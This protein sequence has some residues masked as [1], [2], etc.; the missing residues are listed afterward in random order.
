MAEP[1]YLASLTI[2]PLLATAFFALYFGG[3]AG[4]KFLGEGEGRWQAEGAIR[5][6][7]VAL[8]DEDNTSLSRTL[9]SMLS[10]TPAIRIALA[11]NTFEEGRRSLLRGDCY[12]IAL[13]PKGFEQ[14]CLTFG[15]T[16]ILLYNSGCNLTA[17]GFIA[18]AIQTTAE[19]LSVG[20][21]TQSLQAQGLPA[22]Q[23]MAEAMP[24]RF[25][26]HPLFNPRLDYGWYLAPCFMAM[27]LIIF[28]IAAT[29]TAL[30]SELRY[31]TAGEW[32][33]TAGGSFPIALTGKLLLVTLSMTVAALVM[34]V[35]LRLWLGLPIRG[36]AAMLASATLLLIV[37]YEGISLLF[38]ALT[39]SMRLA[40]SLGGGYSV[41][42]FTFSGITLPVMAMARPLQWL[43]QLFPYTHYTN[44]LIDTTLRGAPTYL[45]LDDAARM[46]LFWIPP[47]LL[48][49]RLERICRDSRYW[50]RL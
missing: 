16:H 22:T 34:A 10:A 23:A 20:V 30:G 14:A 32:L 35:A 50:G 4:E 17:N 28:T 48:M 26:L 29:T 40:F 24:L 1:T 36:S 44:I 42:A 5:P 18:K 45:A 19:S 15:T 9:H 7:P 47:L 21:R 3:E 8:I 38:I 41:L 25:D 43:S 37:C 6:L 46:M 13:I 49:P 31:G 27:M 12:A 33:D 11:T 39:A 2:L